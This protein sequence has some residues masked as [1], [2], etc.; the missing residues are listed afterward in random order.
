MWICK[1]YIGCSLLRQ[2]VANNS[3]VFETTLLSCVWTWWVYPRWGVWDLYFTCVCLKLVFELG[4][5]FETTLLACEDDLLSWV[6]P[7][8]V[9]RLPLDHR[10]RRKNPTSDRMLRWTGSILARSKYFRIGPCQI[11]IFS[12]PILARSKYFQDRS[13]PD[14]NISGSI[15]ARSKYFRINPC[16]IKIFS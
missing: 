12:G 9:G 4:K 5:V 10:G 3:Q 14:Q 6:L 13:L 2:N 1:Q 8:S 15:L 16:Q 11:K 7:V